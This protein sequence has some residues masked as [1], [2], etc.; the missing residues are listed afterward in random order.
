MRVKRI[1][2]ARVISLMVHAIS[3]LILSI[4]IVSQTT[5]FKDLMGAEV[6]SSREPLQPKVRKPVVKIV[7]VPFQMRLFLGS[8]WQQS[9]P[10]KSGYY[11]NQPIIAKQQHHPVGRL[12]ERRR[13][14]KPSVE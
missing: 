6:F 8:S 9:L 4:Y 10:Q 14:V 1:S 3:G 13:V 7:I 5:P 11:M 12:P 2:A